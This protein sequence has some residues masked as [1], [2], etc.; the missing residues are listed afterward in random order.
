MRIL[1]DTH[2]ALWAITGDKRL[3]ASVRTRLRD[4]ANQIYVSAA[5]LWEI[6]IKHRKNPTVMPIGPDVAVQ[7]CGD[8][9]FAWLDIS[10]HHAAASARLPALH[11]DPFDRL[12][13]AQAQQEPMALLTRDAQL[14]TYSELVILA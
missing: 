1:L 10:P 12:L 9:G 13:L 5:S 2:I 8:S 3:A 4:P 7:A 11:A 6:A 14:A